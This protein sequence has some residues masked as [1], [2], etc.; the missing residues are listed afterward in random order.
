ML[1]STR[2]RRYKTA[3]KALAVLTKNNIKRAAVPSLTG[4][5][6][7]ALAYIFS[8]ELLILPYKI[9]ERPQGRSAAVVVVRRRRGIIPPVVVIPVPAGAAR[10]T[11]RRRGRRAK[12]VRTGPS[13]ARTE[14]GTGASGTERRAAV[15]G[16]GAS[17]T[18]RRTAMSGAGTAGT[19]RRTA[20]SRTGAARAECRTAGAGAAGAGAGSDGQGRCEDGGKSDDAQFSAH[21]VTSFEGNI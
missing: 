4:N 21:G 10:R 2:L 14:T 11:T 20:M 5:G 19:E 18:E 17:G 7:A 3:K 13:G 9:E 15:S 8:S 16:T 1:F 12:A 6:T